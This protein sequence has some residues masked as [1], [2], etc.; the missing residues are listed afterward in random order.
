MEEVEKA[1]PVVHN[2]FLQVLDRGQFED[3]NLRENVSFGG[4]ILI[5]TTNLGK[6]LYT[7]R[8]LPGVR[9]TP[10]ASRGV[11]EALRASPH[12]SPGSRP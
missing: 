5:F 3:K 10:V 8:R 2:L 6:D 7:G 11:V 1:N 12:L 9:D 4:T